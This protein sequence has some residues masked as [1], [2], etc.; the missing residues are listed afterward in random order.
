[1]SSKYSFPNIYKNTFFINIFKAKIKKIQLWKRFCAKEEK[2]LI[3]V[4][5]FWYTWLTLKK[6]EGLSRY[7]LRFNR[8][9]QWLVAADEE[10]IRQCL[11]YI[12]NDTR[13]SINI[14]IDLSQINDRVKYFDLFNIECSTIS[15]SS[16]LKNLLLTSLKIVSC[17]LIQAVANN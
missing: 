10:I 12:F 16:R 1:M 17:L 14:D 7:M 9:S 3:R 5:Y 8:H 11:D 13:N 15:D 2:K 6:G 4:K